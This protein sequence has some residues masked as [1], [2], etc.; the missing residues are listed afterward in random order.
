MAWQKN[1]GNINIGTLI[2]TLSCKQSIGLLEREARSMSTN[3]NNED[4]Q[5]KSRFMDLANKAYSRD[6]CTFTNFLGLAELNVFYQS[7]Q[8]L[9]YIDTDIFGGM[10]DSERKIVRFGRLNTEYPISCIH[11]IPSLKK[12][13]DKLSHRDFL[14]AIINLGIKRDTLGDIIVLDNEAY[15]FCLSNI[16]D[17]IIQNLDRIKHTSVKCAYSRQI[18]TEIINRIEDKEFN[19]ASLRLD[20]IIGEIYKLSRSQSQSFIHDKRVF[21]NGRLTENN[22]YQVKP[23]DKIT[24]RG[25]GKFIFGDTIRS[26]KKGRFFV[27]AQVYL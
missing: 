25:M 11:I 3:M 26:T 13:S 23:Y 21:V 9:S 19:V 4:E 2:G 27:N 1:C 20:A 5:L 17:F 24:V 10:E 12:F 8:D 15:V 16:A 14:G 6:I 18:P 7:E 22:S